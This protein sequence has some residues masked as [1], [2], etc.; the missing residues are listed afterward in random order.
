MTTCTT[1]APRG[2]PS[3]ALAALLTLAATHLA[4]TSSPALAS[5]GRLT[6]E[7]GKAL[8]ASMPRNDDFPIVMND[9]VLENLNEILSRP[10]RAR[11]LKNALARMQQHQP[12]L[13]ARLEKHDLPDALLAVPLVESGYRN[14]KE[15]KL[16]KHPKAARA[17][18]IWMFLGATARHYGLRVDGRY[19]DRLDPG[20]ETEA[21][22]RYLEANFNRYGDWILALA[23][24]N[25]GPPAVDRII[26]KAGHRDAW[27]LIDDGHINE[28]AARVMANVILMRNPHLL[29]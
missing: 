6:L 4:L 11:D 16:K 7:E 28:Y 15:P 22:A 29:R 27:Q 10:G 5:R 23:A 9:T 13:A 2:R 24:Y 8:V 1:R 21:A 25:M 26:K 3:L 14:V 17:A 19:D 12:M 20:R 18:G